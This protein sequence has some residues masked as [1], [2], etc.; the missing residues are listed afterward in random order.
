M[1]HRGLRTCR[2]AACLTHSKAALHFVLDLAQVGLYRFISCCAEKETISFSCGSSLL[3][4]IDVIN[5]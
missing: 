1:E 5:C 3:A 4:D 2:A